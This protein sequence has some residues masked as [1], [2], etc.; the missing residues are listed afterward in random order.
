MPSSSSCATWVSKLAGT[1]L[2][3]LASYWFSSE[4]KLIPWQVTSAW[5]LWNRQ[6]YVAWY[7][8]FGNGSGPHAANLNLWRENCAGPATSCLG[9]APTSDPYMCWFH[10]SSHQ[11][12]SA[13]L[14]TYRRIWPGGI[15]GS[16]MGKT[17]DIFGP[18]PLP[19]VYLS[20]PVPMLAEPS[21]AVTCFMHTGPMMFHG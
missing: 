2:W 14:V 13:A 7:T 3:T 19:L 16:T 9:V 20:M 12:T 15:I 11:P 5:N 6:N 4:S 1:K 10:P 8:P 17:G 21:A 18:Q